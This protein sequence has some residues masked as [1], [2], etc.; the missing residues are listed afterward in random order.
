VRFSGAAALI[1]LFTLGLGR[2]GGIEAAG[3]VLVYAILPVYCALVASS[4]ACIVA[5][6]ASTA[7]YALL[8]GMQSSGWL[9]LPAVTST[10]N[11][12]MA[13]VNLLFLNVVGVLTA[14]L[15]ETHR[16]R[17]QR[18]TALNGELE[19]AHDQ[20]QRLNAEIQ[21]AAQQRVL[22][23]IVAGV[24]HDLGNVLSV[25]SGYLGLARKKAT[26]VAEVDAYLA[27]VEQSFDGAMQIIRNTLQIARQPVAEPVAVS[28]ADIARRVLELKAYDLRRDGIVAR[29]NFPAQFPRVRCGAPFQLEQALLNL[30]TNAQ[31][32]LREVDGPR[33]IRVAGLLTAGGIAVEVSDTGPGIPAESLAKV[34][35]PFYS[36]KRDGAGLGLAIAAE[37][38]RGLD[39]EITV[40]NRRGGGASFRIRLPAAPSA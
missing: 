26:H 28:V 32:A 30:V 6:A 8:V 23:E 27:H 7:C 21:R 16:R 12:V 25:A 5:A 29:V 38:A 36:S 9:P 31:E 22:G 15:S 33:E 17:D 19:R 39:G 3:F 20:A 10:G 34:F 24:T 18:H 40:E 1:I 4:T 2:L 14:V 11:V 35:E 37:I 13:G